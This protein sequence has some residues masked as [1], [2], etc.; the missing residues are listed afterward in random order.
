[1]V[2]IWRVEA[3]SYLQLEMSKGFDAADIV[4]PSLKEKISYTDRVKM[5]EIVIMLV[6]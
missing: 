6:C 3:E 2:I 5:Q 4:L 1:M